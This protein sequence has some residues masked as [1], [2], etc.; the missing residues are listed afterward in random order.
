MWQV[1]GPMRDGATLA[2]ARPVLERLA[3]AGW[4]GRL[5]RALVDAA[6]QRRASLGAHWREDA[7]LP[8]AIGCAA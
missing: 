7:G 6:V 2:G 4:Q 5:A 8:R 3:S 1:M